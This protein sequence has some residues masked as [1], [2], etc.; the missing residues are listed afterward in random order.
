M[1]N[2]YIYVGGKR[3]NRTLITFDNG[4]SWHSIAAPANINDV[5]SN[6]TLVSVIFAC[7]LHIRRLAYIKYAHNT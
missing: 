5:P 2:Q 6:C 7:Y 1:A 4:A 3:R